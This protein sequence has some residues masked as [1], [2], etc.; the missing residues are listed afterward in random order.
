MQFSGKRVVVTGACGVHG[1]WIAAAFAREGATLCLSDRRADELAAAAAKI[2]P[3]APTHPTELTDARSIAGLAKLVED[4][5]GAPDIVVN[6]AGIYPRGLL[7][8]I[9]AAEWDRIM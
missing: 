9:D 5:W 3:G 8:D 2:A 7:L 6:N 1:A 4:R